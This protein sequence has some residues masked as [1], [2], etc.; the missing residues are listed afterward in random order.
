MLDSQTNAVTA[1]NK[2]NCLLDNIIPTMHEEAT[3]KDKQDLID[4]Y[5]AQLREFEEKGKNQETRF[6]RL[7]QGIEAF[8]KDLKEAIKQNQG[9]A[10]EELKTVQANIKALKEELDKTNGF[11]TNCVDT[12]GKVAGMASST[13]GILKLAPGIIP[14]FLSALSVFGNALGPIKQKA[15]ERNEKLNQLNSFEKQE[16]NILARIED[17]KQA[18]NEVNALDKTFEHLA[19]RLG[20]LQSIWRSLDKD[21][22]TLRESLTAMEKAIHGGSK[23]SIEVK[24]RSM[25]PSYKLFA[26]ALDAYC[27][28]TAPKQ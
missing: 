14:S 17:L 28:A 8:Q 13:S 22:Q 7:R 24:T 9:T 11:W 15:D 23:L 10:S 26:T 2:I 18:A 3:I 27:S 1:R 19:D 6:L 20:A 4:E 25:I 5:V 12:L 21:A 16:T